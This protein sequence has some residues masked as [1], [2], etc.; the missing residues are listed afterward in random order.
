ML[1]LV[2]YHLLPQP[3]QHPGRVAG[4]IA[5]LCLRLVDLLAATTIGANDLEQV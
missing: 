5:D 3:H 1:D 2:T 4:V